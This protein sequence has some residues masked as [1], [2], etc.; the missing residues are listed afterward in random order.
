MIKS[1]LIWLFLLPCFS[2]AGLFNP[3]ADSLILKGIDLTIETDFDSALICFQ[4]ISRI[5][6]EHPAGSFYVASVYQSMMMHYETGRWQTQFFAYVDTTL[7]RSEKW[8]LNHP[9]DAWNYFFRGSILSYQGLYEAKTGSL[10]NGFK[11]AKQGV[12]ELKTALELDSTLYDA[13]VGIGNYKY[14]A[15]KY[16]KYLRWLPYIRDERAQGMQEVVKG[17][18]KGCFSYWIGCNS[19]AWIHYDRDEFDDA[20]VLFEE[21]ALRFDNGLMWLWGLADTYKKAEKWETASNLYREIIRSVRSDSLESGYNEVLARWKTI[22]CLEALGRFEEIAPEYQAM[23]EKSV[24]GMRR[25]KAE[26]CRKKA[27]IAAERAGKMI[28]KRNR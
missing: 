16:Y 2:F 25:E 14:W 24:I 27:G 11:H 10:I 26:D 13:H 21:G 5:F 9:D 8:A 12:D 17:M 22:Q 23:L 6:P 28:E 4:K 7:T 18:Q 15:G 3:S 20:A 19:L 1:F